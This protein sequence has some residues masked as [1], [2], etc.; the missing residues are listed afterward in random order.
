MYTIFYA[1]SEFRSLKENK[2]E[3]KET[4]SR[5]SLTIYPVPGTILLLSLHLRFRTTLE[6]TTH[7]HSFNTENQKAEK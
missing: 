3:W 5:H 1:F 6:I 7:Y 4:K 2:M